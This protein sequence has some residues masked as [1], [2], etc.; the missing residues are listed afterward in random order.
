MT[1]EQIKKV[2]RLIEIEYPTANRD[3]TAEDLKMKLT[4][5]EVQ[6]GAYDSELVFTALYNYIA[7]NKFPPTLAGVFEEMNKL[8]TTGDESQQL[9]GHLTKLCR[10]A[11]TITAEDFQ[12]I[13]E[14]LRLWIGNLQNLKAL[15]QIDEATFSTVTRGQF[16]REIQPIISHKEAKDRVQN[17]KLGERYNDKPKIG[18]NMRQLPKF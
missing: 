12:E 2:L 10:K 16:L 9:W 13:P 1:R 11:S 18:A 7:H 4:L 17:L 8:A 14:E 15:G 6:L 3:M 5:W